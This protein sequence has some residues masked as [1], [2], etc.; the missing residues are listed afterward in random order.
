MCGLWSP[1]LSD[2]VD[3]LKIMSQVMTMVAGPNL[4]NCICIMLLCCMLLSLHLPLVA[5]QPA[6]VSLLRRLT[7]PAVHPTDSLSQTKPCR[8][9]LLCCGA[10]L[11]A[12]WS[13]HW[14]ISWLGEISVKILKF[15]TL[16][17][18]TIDISSYLWYITYYDKAY[19]HRANGIM[20]GNVQLWNWFLS[21]KFSNYVTIN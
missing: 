20:Q 12:G 6:T 21:G 10:R 8:S 3:W 16:A 7:P 5:L 2:K 18:K 1:K 9:K 19:W 4:I 11:A 15:L 17:L 14:S 13:C